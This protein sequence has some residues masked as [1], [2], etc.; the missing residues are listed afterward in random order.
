VPG[1]PTH[2]A[3]VQY[4]HAPDADHS[5]L[6]SGA[7]LRSAPGHPAFP[8]RLGLELF[9]RAL[10][11]RAPRGPVTVWDPCC[12]SG[13]LLVAVALL[14]RR[15]VRAVVGSDAAPAALAIAEQNLALLTVAGLA[16]RERELHD[17]VDAHG[18]ASHERA[19]AAAGRLA[20]RLAA[21][22]GDVSTARHE[23]N[24]LDPARLTPVAARHAPEIVLADVPHGAQT[25]WAPH[26]QRTG[27]AAL[28]AA[29]G[30]VL[31][32][33]SV[34]VV[35]DR[36]RRVELP[37]GVVALERLRVGHRAA[38]LVRAGDVGRGGR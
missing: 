14:R 28:V 3:R 38:A 12:G 5:D 17:L 26:G 18:K 27:P 29:L 2:T 11:H 1:G 4:R 15:D 37:A 20:R 19:S 30:Q 33:T 31:P 22:G 9:G 34:L 21:E 10:A 23:A 8:V 32:A 7:V 25:E 6:A 13:Q 35:V 36:A 16:A 24:A